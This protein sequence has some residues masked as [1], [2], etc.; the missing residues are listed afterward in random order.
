MRTLVFI[1]V[2]F[3][4]VAPALAGEVTVVVKVEEGKP[5]FELD[6]KRYGHFEIPG[7]L[8]QLSQKDSGVVVSIAADQKLA[9][10]YVFVAI[11]DT[12]VSNVGG[13]TLKPAGAA[14]VKLEMLD[15]RE[16]AEAKEEKVP[17]KFAPI[18][19]TNPKHQIRKRSAELKL[20]LAEGKGVFP[21]KELAV[22][23]KAGDLDNVL[24]VLRIDAHATFAG[25]ADFYARVRG[26]GFSAVSFWLP[27][28]EFEI[29]FDGDTVTV[30]DDNGK[31]KCDWN[32]EAVTEAQLI[33]K[34]R[35][36]GKV[37]A[38]KLRLA[39][40]KDV[41][42][43]HIA[44]VIAA[45]AKSGVEEV[46]MKPTGGEMLEFRMPKVPDV[47]EQDGIDV[48]R[49]IDMKLSV[50]DGKTVLPEKEFLELNNLDRK[51]M[52]VMMP[53]KEIPYGD[54]VEFCR[55]CRKLGF[56]RIFF[57]MP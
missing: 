4:G 1:L 18:S 35:K 28:N 10:G 24:V 19:D 47:P 56:E 33:E 43:Q 32:G 11:V 2:M 16:T 34:L 31:I 46:T 12:A 51:A 45:F 17:P 14:E 39:A 53:T 23:V 8:R 44:K 9:F 29:F 6:G 30:R 55:R 20:E 26:A 15:K 3:L 5:F 37:E 27:L 36:L 50:K 49:R 48:P 25:A 21:E 7:V 41:P 52:V 40:A 38:E 13:I 54:L 22:L 42:Y 57:A